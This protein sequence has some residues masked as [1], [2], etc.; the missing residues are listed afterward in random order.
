MKS[1]DKDNDREISLY[2]MKDTVKDFLQMALHVVDTDGDDKVSLEELK[3]IA[4][5]DTL[6][7]TLMSVFDENGDGDLSYKE[8]MQLGDMAMTS[9]SKRNSTLRLYLAMASITPLLTIVTLVSLCNAETE[10]AKIFTDIGNSQVLFINKQLSYTDAERKC[11]KLGAELA[12]I[13]TE[14]EWVEVI[15]ASVGIVT[16]HLPFESLIR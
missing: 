2:E 16:N 13:R 11:K 10:C 14:E 6:P 4:N 3:H 5:P 8:F 12:E 1:L 7:E 15:K 9:E